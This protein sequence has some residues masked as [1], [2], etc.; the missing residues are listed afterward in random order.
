MKRIAKYLFQSLLIAPVLLVLF[1]S[2]VNGNVPAAGFYKL[3]DWKGINDTIVDDTTKLQY[4]F[5]DYDDPYTKRNQNS[6][7]YLK[8]PSNVQTQIEYDPVTGEYVIKEKV[9]DIDVRPSSTMSSEE[10]KNFTK[11]NSISDYW[12]EQR[13]ANNQGSANDNFLQKYLNPKLNVNIKGFDKIFGSNVIDIKPQ[14]SAELIFGVNIS[15]IENPTLPLNLQRSTTFDFDMKIQM[16]VTGKI[17]EKMQ[18]GIN[19]NTEAQ[20]DFENQTTITYTGDEDEIIQSIEAGNVS[21]PLTGTLITGSQSLFGLKTALQFGKLRVTSIFSQQKS[22]SSTITVEGGAQTKDYEINVAEYEANKHFFL[23]H[24][25]KDNY[26]RALQNLPV[27][28]SGINITRIEVWV[29]NKTGNF[30][31]A[32]NIIGFMDLAEGNS[33]NIYRDDFVTPGSLAFPSN[34]ANNLYSNMSTTYS[35]IRNI[36]QISST[37]AGIPDFEPIIDYA[38]IENARLLSPNEY[39]IHPKLGYISLNSPLNDDEVLAVAYEYTVGGRTYKVGEFSNGGITAPST[40]ILKLIKGPSL[41]PYIPAWDLMMKNVYSIGSYQINSEDFR[42]NILYNDDETGTTVNYIDAGNIKGTPLLK[43]MNLDQLN[44]QLDPQP[45]GY[46][47]FIDKLTI[48][49]SNGRIFFPVREPFGEY[50]R[51]KI[52]DDAN[53]DKYVFEELYDSTQS[54]AKQLAEKSK[55]I[56][57]GSYKSSGG[58]EISLNAFNI[59]EGSVK[60]SANG[61]ELVEGTQYLVDYNLGRVTILDQSLLASGTPIKI[62]L[63]N[64]SLFNINRRTLLGTHLD[65]VIS[66]N[67]ALGGTILHLSEKP[68]TNKVNIGSEPISNTIWGI[69]GRFSTEAPFLT[70]MIDGLPFI[71][72]KETSTIEVSG[73]FAHLIP[74]HSKTIGKNGN[75]YI[76]DFEGAKTSIDLKAQYEWALASTPK[77]QSDMFPEGNTDS[78]SNGFNRAKLAWYNVNT[79]L[80]R[81]NVGSVASN[82]SVTDQ[83]NHFVR[84]VREQEIF[85][86]K[87]DVT[88]YP[89]I[90]NIF[91]V[92]FYPDERGPYNYDVDETAYSK[93]VDESGKL[94]D[95][96][97]RWGGIMRDL[98]TN[99][100]EAANIEYV[101]FWMM[102]PF[103]YEPN[104]TGGDLYF[105]LGYISEDILKDGRKSFENGLPTT[106]TVD[107]VDTTR[108]GRVP[109]QQSL[110]PAFDNNPTARTYQDVGFDGLNDVEEASFFRDYITK[111]QSK[112]TDPKAR[113]DILKDP[114]SDNYHFFRGSDY[115]AE[116]NFTI[117]DRYKKFN[118]PDG[119]S[120]TASQS[121]EDYPTSATL[122]PDVEDIN[123][124]NTLNEEEAYFQY[125]VRLDPGSMEEA[126]KNFITDIV[127]PKSF[128]LKGRTITPPKWYQFKI[129]IKE[130]E[131]KHGP[132]SDF[133]S[134]R[135]VRMFMRGF[136]DT[137]VARFAKLDLVRSEWRDYEGGI[138]E[139]AEGTGNPQPLADEGF[140]I[141]VVSIEENGSRTPVNYV[142]PPGISRVTD[143]T[144]PY[145]VQLNEQSI[146]FKVTDL[147]DGDARAAYKN[148]NLDIRQYGKLQMEVHGEEVEP[149]TLKNNELTVFLRIGSDYKENYYEVEIPLQL[150]EWKSNYDNESET[151][152][153]SVWPEANRFNFELDLLQ[154]VKQHRNNK[155]REPGTNTTLSSFYSEA[156]GENMVIS[157]V[158]NPN[159]SNVKTIM[160]GVRNPDQQR[161]NN[162]S[163][164]HGFPKSG[165]IWFNELRL[166]DFREK[167][168]WAA[169]GLVKT[170]LA[171]LGNVTVSASKSTHGFGSLDSKIEDRQKEDIFQYDVSSNMELGKFFP[172]KYGVRIPVYFGFSENIQTP[173]YNPL[174]PDILMK[175]TLND[176]EISA[177]EKDSIRRIVIDYTRRKSFNVTNL[178]I[179][180][181]PDRLKGKKKRFYHISNF[182]TSFAYN[183]LYSRNIKT[184]Y[185][186]QRN[187]TGSFSYVFNNRPKAVEPF[188]KVK[189]LN[190]KAFRLVKDM[191]FYLGPTLVSFRTDMVRKYQQSLIRDITLENSIIEPTYKKDF[192]WNRNYDL[193]YS[194]TKGLKFEYSATNKARIDEKEGI[195]D[196][197]SP[198]YQAMKDTL[199][200]N[201][202][203][204]GRNINYNHSINASYTIPIDKIPLLGWTSAT[205][206]YKATFDWTASPQLDTIQL[207]NTLSNSN[208]INL[209]SSLNFSKIYSKVP[210]LKNISDKMKRGANANKKY[211]DVKF[212]KEN[213]KLKEGV[214]KSIVHNLQTEDVQIKVTDENGKEVEGELIVVNNKK[215][216]FRAKG[217]V[218]NAN[219]EVTGKKEIKQNFLKSIG[220]GLVN[221]T[222]GL[223]NI[224][225]SYS[226]TSGTL[227]PGY[228]P[229]TRYS[230]L[231]EFQDSAGVSRWA[232]GV[233][234]ALGWQDEN[235]GYNAYNKY[236]W[237]SKHPLQTSPYQ[238]TYTQN[239]SAKASL[240][241]LKGL[242]IDLSVNR[243]ISKNRNEYD[244]GNPNEKYF[245][246]NF[247]MSYLM[248]NTAFWTFGSDYSSEAFENFKTNRVTVAWRLAEKRNDARL[249][250]SPDYDINQLNIDPETGDRYPNGYGPT[251]QDVMIPAFLA[252]YGGRS[253]DKIDLSTFPKFPLPNWRITYD[254]LSEMDLV[255]RIIK[256]INLTH[257][258]NATYNVG[259]YETNAN[260]NWYDVAYDGNSW[261]R[262]EVKDLFIPERQIGAITLTEAFNPLIGA[263]VTW[264]NNLSSKFEY[265]KGR[266]MTLNFTNNVV[267]D[268]INK[269]III[270]LGY[271]FDQLPIIIKTGKGQQ[272]FKSDLNLRGDLSIMDQLSIIRKIEE[273]VDQIQG[274]QKALSLKLSA[275]YALNERFN[276]R[277]FYDHAINTPRLSTSYRTSNIKFGVSVRFTLIP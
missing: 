157:V 129:P 105:D 23:A 267:T 185:N 75:A 114:S 37:L 29:T 269:E 158:G 245:T 130:W 135:F 182:S 277:L 216:K 244:L 52:S 73:E 59:P 20:F 198:N 228:L 121:K 233:P 70:R 214:G 231:N 78:L 188:K 166:T 230:G 199:W 69:D 175:T 87:D 202:M 58:S 260:Y 104:H 3:N 94:I 225:L 33:A 137:I 96:Q 200:E 167:G 47:D 180:G 229:T 41:Q 271:R 48:N 32:R 30:E 93:G 91:N 44:S 268:L 25:F 111:I 133:R 241:P 192:T 145:L 221:I 204:G 257:S 28:A 84:E 60:V 222:I 24:Y 219:V 42:L 276:L 8:N 163:D 262:D 103:V 9:G 168:G 6:P 211:K 275:D 35:G 11:R 154:Q 171:D 77:G 173:E 161:S 210:F 232:P 39:T 274:G 132:I 237:V 123:Q 238:M 206:R 100:F 122:M 184:E 12:V 82:I 92:V 64:N 155:M 273:G 45:D 247:S 256:N 126:G 146:Q 220:E 4:P 149:N 21:L 170:K 148:L 235:F 63:E 88:G 179:E 176:P 98:Q 266:T 272:K 197:N 152:R 191:N 270:G 50:L 65:Y 140:E 142:L 102:D 165:I 240:E 226:E 201:I 19:Y 56:L 67:F 151:D 183:E 162:F 265:N 72:T 74:G 174:D 66:E 195:M 246:G 181:D 156:A 134:I 242:K 208:T 5:E 196:K 178:K 17:G 95:P 16:G 253:P 143:P 36:N 55:F 250:A 43:V 169:N 160:L 215:V 227:L 255:K 1:H 34:D 57:K 68:L 27:I 85:P 207:G 106:S 46:F 264:I 190:K 177:E 51:N 254:G 147:G 150:T 125:H 76:D 194:L 18:V 136:E 189:F 117:M 80:L 249:I 14:G 131:S 2:N 81:D 38:K 223:K 54:K 79:D 164:D 212:V 10:F 49:A 139:G 7:L 153:R 22:E 252:A 86:N 109:L 218:D 90:L 236:G 119:N 186:I 261:A 224:S 205:A 193:K 107:L 258:Y 15:K 108:W 53:A 62:S 89:T 127:Q 209:S 40:L 112:V 118:G 248:W 213:V 71:E 144:N 97:S 26:D 31:N 101:E 110:V 116:P 13:K 243:T 115:D 217:N 251:S 234:F 187:Y 128:E 263:D 239:I 138:P 124:D 99:D 113:A 203:R 172:S 120:P 159:L 61:Q 83:L 259:S 141:S